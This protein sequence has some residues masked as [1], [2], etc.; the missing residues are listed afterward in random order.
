LF[1]DAGAFS[2]NGNIESVWNLGV[3]IKIRKLFQ[4][5]FPVVMSQNLMDSYTSNSYWNKI[6]VSVNLNMLTHPFQLRNIF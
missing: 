3:G 1:A 2:N 5:H 4:I 6:R